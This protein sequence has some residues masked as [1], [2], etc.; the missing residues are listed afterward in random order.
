MATVLMIFAEIEPNQ[1]NQN[2]EDFSRFLVRGLCLE[3]ALC[4]SSNST[5]LNPALLLL[6]KRKPFTVGVV[7]E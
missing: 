3:W 7:S 2:R 1:N 5:R 4:C 6:A